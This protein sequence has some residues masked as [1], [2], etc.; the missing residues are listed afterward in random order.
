MWTMDGNFEAFLRQIWGHPLLTAAIFCVLY[1][2]LASLRERL[3]WRESTLARNRS[4]RSGFYQP[5]KIASKI[6]PR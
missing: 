2:Y 3:H 4:D 1:V 5:M 6:F